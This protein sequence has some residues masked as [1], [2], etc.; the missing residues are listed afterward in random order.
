MKHPQNASSPAAT[1][2]ERHSFS[3]TNTA[4]VAKDP[5]RVWRTERLALLKRS[6]EYKALPPIYRKIVD[7]LVRAHESADQG[8]TVAA[9]TLAEKYGV[10]L[11]TMQTYLHEID[12]AGVFISEATYKGRGKRGL[13]GGGRST[14]RR[15]L[16]PA[17]LAREAALMGIEDSFTHSSTSAS[18]SASTDSQKVYYVDHAEAEAPTEPLHS[19][20]PQLENTAASP[21]G[22]A[23]EGQGRTLDRGLAES[24]QAAVTRHACCEVCRVE[25]VPGRT[26][27]CRGDEE[28]PF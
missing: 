26:H 12:Q 27:E 11:R 1:E 3:N 24:G 17:I 18:T 23:G 21:D 15:R 28:V 16:N 7:Y 2:L 14:N 10:H 4:S 22:S 19:E 8:I 13:T 9:E 25:L 6:P 20:A 5:L